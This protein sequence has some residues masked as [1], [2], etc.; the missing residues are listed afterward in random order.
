MSEFWKPDA[1]RGASTLNAMDLT[2]TKE[3]PP[4][5]PWTE[6]FSSGFESS[7]TLVQREPVETTIN[8]DSIRDIAFADGYNEGRRT[9]ELEVG[10]EREAV[11]RL[12]EMLEQYRPEPPAELASLL[13]ETVDRLVRQI[14][15]EAV[16]DADLLDKRVAVVAQLIADASAPRRMR[17]HPDDIKRLEGAD[18]D[19]EII[20]D[21]GMLPGS[22]FVETG[23]GWVEDGPDVGLEKLRQALE[24]M[25]ISQ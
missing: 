5:V 22:V 15:G 8:L 9:V 20:P 16:I 10:A 13:A 17:L 3:R 4:F 18:L 25:G 14:V 19:V 21:A 1:A 2:G 23:T 24:R 12:A 11:A 7:A 6:K